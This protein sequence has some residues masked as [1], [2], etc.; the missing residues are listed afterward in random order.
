MAAPDFWADKFKAQ[1]KIK[2]LGELKDK[3]EGVGKYDKGNA[4]LTI[5]S[6]AGGDDAEDFSAMLL[7]M[8][9][10]YSDKKRWEISFIHEHKNDHD[11]YRNVSFEVEG[12]GAYGTLK[13]ESGGPRLVRVSPFNAKETFLSPSWS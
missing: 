13:H 10:K 4:V 12:R 8:Y 7:T 3:L 9:M 6:G 1:S 11:G 2:E 5:I